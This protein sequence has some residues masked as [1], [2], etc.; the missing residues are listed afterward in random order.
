VAVDRE[1][2]RWVRNAADELAAKAGM[3]FDAERGAFACG[4][5]ESYC[6][7]YEGEHAGEPMILLPAWR[8]FFMRLYGWVRWSEEW[9]QWIRR[10]THASFW[11]AKK[12]GKSPNCAA[13]N[14][15]LLCGDGEQGQHVY[16]AAADG[17]NARI[18]QMHAVNMVRQ[19]PALAADCKVNNTTLQ[20]THLPTNSTLS[21]L[22][23]DDS[24]GA[25]TKEG[26]NGSV[27]YDEMHV[28]NR[29]MEE[30]TNRAGISRKEPINASF[31]TAGDDPSS[32][33]FERCEYGRQVNRGERH[34][35]HFLH[36][37][38]TAPADNPTDARVD[39][40]LDEYGKAA[41]PAW[42]AL[43]KPSEFRAD[44]QRS[45]GK[46]REV[47]RFK[48]YRLSLWVGSTNPWLD[49]AGW[50]RGRRA[51]TLADLAGRDCLLGIDLSRTRDMTAAVLLF[52]WPEDGEDC[53]RLW[54]MF[55]LPEET[56][57][58]R[59]HLF[60]F[61]SWAA[62]GHLTL[63]PGGVV[64]YAAVKADVRA[65]VAAHNLNLLG[66]YYDAHYANELTQE[67]V[68]GEEVGDA[69]VP[70]L[71]CERVTVGQTLMVLSPL[72]KEWER[73]VIAG[74]VHHPGNPVMTWQVGHCQVWQDRNQNVRPVKPSPHSGKS[75]DGIMAA[76]DAM[77]GVA[78]GTGATTFIN[79]R[80]LVM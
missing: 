66:L 10:F 31:S 7:L 48:Q 33:G 41:N 3:R 62:A 35:P 6:H 52:P 59:D 58:E 73:L 50:E 17:Q 21:I 57:R 36:V 71:G 16:Q 44:W 13:H 19:S 15:Y 12:N 69:R 55:W 67:L 32:V 24:R 72:A 74:K 80:P 8:D 64:D 43:V 53:L 20:I 68:E 2:K 18:A 42:G 34:D 28:V 9:G 76:L 30:R 5:I 4:W 79:A 45:K 54:P 11:G 56:A 61:V 78:S 47:A 39:E 27:S 37:E 65:A 63:T 46:P 25:K 14:L 60:P 26:L 51:Y 70:G 77:A 1:T 40:H 49:A 22:C 23:G 29:E 75:I 38:Y